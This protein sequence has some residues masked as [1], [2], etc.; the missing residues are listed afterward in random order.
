MILTGV[1]GCPSRH[2]ASPVL[3]V[4]IGLRINFS[5]MTLP[6]RP[7]SPSRSSTRPANVF[8]SA[9]GRLEDCR[10]ACSRAVLDGASAV[11]SVPVLVPEDSVYAA[12]RR[13]SERDE[14]ATKAIHAA[15]GMGRQGF[16]SCLFAWRVTRPAGCRM[17][18]PVVNRANP[19]PAKIRSRL[20]RRR[21]EIPRVGHHRI[22]DPLRR[23]I[24][25]RVR[26]SVMGV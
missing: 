18:T 17:M 16:S 23:R 14:P 22:R 24:A 6:P 5:M 2:P 8:H 21:A 9:P 13:E 10:P 15:G 20:S 19:S 7:T 12:G 26:R 3:G 25:Q 1:G 11:L 4:G